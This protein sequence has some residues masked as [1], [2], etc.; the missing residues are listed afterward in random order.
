MKF[1]IE[2]DIFPCERSSPKIDL[3]IAMRTIAR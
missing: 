1:C 2:V 3:Y